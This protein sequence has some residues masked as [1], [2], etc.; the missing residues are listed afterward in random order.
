MDNN[1][2]VLPSIYPDVISHKDTGGLD[3]I[4]ISSDSDNSE[5]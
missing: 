5:N 1:N 2:L 3:D 4:D